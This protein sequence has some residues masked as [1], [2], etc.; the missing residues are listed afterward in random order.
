MLARDYV[1]GGCR[2]Y[3][4]DLSANLLSSHPSLTSRFSDAQR[5]PNGC[6]AASGW[7]T[8]KETH[9]SR[10][11]TEVAE[12]ERTCPRTPNR[13]TRTDASNTRKHTQHATRNT[14]HATRSTQHATPPANVYTAPQHQTAPA[15]NNQQPRYGK[16]VAFSDSSVWPAWLSATPTPHRSAFPTQVF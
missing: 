8:T 14:Q 4:P 3:R 6:P 12:C 10:I 11:I 15:T 9:C 2:I 1:A 13:S 7:V 16:F 5:M